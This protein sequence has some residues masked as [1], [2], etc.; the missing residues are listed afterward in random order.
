VIDGLQ[1]V[2]FLFGLLSKRE[3]RRRLERE[4]GE[5]A[6]QDISEL[7]GGISPSMVWESF[8]LVAQG[9]HERIKSNLL[10]IFL[11]LMK[12]PLTI[13]RMLHFLNRE[14]LFAPSSTRQIF[15]RLVLRLQ[16]AFDHQ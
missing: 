15:G 12:H 14:L 2:S 9:F 3:Q 1:V 8:K 10:L 7:I 11:V 16:A 13:Q 6:A 4:Q 5:G